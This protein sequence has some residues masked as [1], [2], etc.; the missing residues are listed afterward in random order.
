MRQRDLYVSFLNAQWVAVLWV[1]VLVV[2]V[3]LFEMP[4]SLDLM[5]GR[6][7]SFV[8]LLFVSLLV[9]NTRAKARRRRVWKKSDE[10]VFVIFPVILFLAA[11]VF[12][13]L[14]SV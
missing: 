5:Y 10:W 12:F 14:A 7:I 13:T 3:F 11:S 6:L 9:R 4:F 1:T 2:P 8:V